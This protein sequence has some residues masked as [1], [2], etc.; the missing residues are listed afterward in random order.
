MEQRQTQLRSI[1]ASEKQPKQAAA[2]DGLSVPVIERFLRTG[3]ETWDGAGSGRFTP[4]QFENNE[5]YRRAAKDGLRT[6]L[7]LLA[8]LLPAEA[9]SAPQVAPEMIRR[10][11]EPMVKGTCAGRLAGSRP[12]RDHRTNLRFE[13]PG[14]P[15]PPWT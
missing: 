9:Q 14:E 11:I 3:D 12:P 15:R 5:A 1:S 7:H 2:V 6:L 4:A 8:N 10:R 13:F